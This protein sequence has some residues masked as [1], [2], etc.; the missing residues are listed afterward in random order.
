MFEHYYKAIGVLLG[1][2]LAFCYAA[3]WFVQFL[4]FCTVGVLAIFILAVIEVFVEHR[5]ACAAEKRAIAD[6]ADRQHAAALK[7]EDYGTYGEFMPPKE[8]RLWTR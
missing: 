8:L 4:L 3:A 5:D 6:R 7:G 1:A 2:A